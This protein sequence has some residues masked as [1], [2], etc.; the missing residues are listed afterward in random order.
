[1][2]ARTTSHFQQRNRH[3]HTRTHTHHTNAH[4]SHKRTHRDAQRHT[5]AHTHTHNQYRTHLEQVT[6]RGIALGED[7]HNDGRA[8]GQSPRHQRSRP[9][10]DL[11]VQKPL[12][13]VLQP[14]T[15][16]TAARGRVTTTHTRRTMWA[17][18]STYKHAHT[19]GRHTCPSSSTI[20]PQPTSRCPRCTVTQAPTHLTGVQISSVHVWASMSRDVTT[21]NRT[22]AVRGGLWGVVAGF[23]QEQETK[24]ET[25]IPPRQY[26]FLLHHCHHHHIHRRATQSHTS[27]GLC[28]IHHTVVPAKATCA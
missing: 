2:P 16:Q 15:Q 19:P 5:H 1:M 6:Q 18:S 27:P 11:Q 13:H 4:T 12:H 24:R 22:A 14:R 25:P 8:N 3:Q 26:S 7:C 21:H 20:D 10:G 9:D 17:P 28:T 23:Q